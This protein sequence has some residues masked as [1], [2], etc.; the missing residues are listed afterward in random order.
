MMLFW[1][2][3]FLCLGNIVAESDDDLLS[4]VTVSPD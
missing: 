4:F 2:L 3:F 1:I